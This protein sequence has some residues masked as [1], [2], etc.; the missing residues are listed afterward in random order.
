MI[1]GVVLAAGQGQRIGRPK[2]WLRTAREGE[3]FFGRACTVLA[4][5]GVDRVIGIIP[6]GGEAQAHGAAPGAI[7]IVNRWP[8]EG[9]LASLQLALAAIGALQVET[10]A[11]VVLPVDV[12]LVKE[13]TV[14][15]LIARWREARPAVVRPVSTDGRHG[16]PVMCSAALFERLLA[17]DPSVG[18]KPIVREHASADGDVL[19]DD[20]GAFI[21]IDTVEDYTR[22]F[23]QLP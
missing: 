23:G 5:G 3:S 17:A 1:V 19:I 10:E 22:V 4:G 12:P 18:A 8:E 14:R 9:Q 20:E 11:A 13:D 15:A 6:A 2:A 16:H 21:D 7:L